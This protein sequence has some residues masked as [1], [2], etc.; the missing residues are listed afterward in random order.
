MFGI[1]RGDWNGLEVGVVKSL[2]S[3][4]IVKSIFLIGAKAKVSREK[5]ETMA[6]WG[7]RLNRLEFLKC[8]AEEGIGICGKGPQG[9]VNLM[10][11]SYSI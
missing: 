2:Y 5:G 1:S 6:H 8:L 3:V 10:Y 7:V 11:S 4:L 9:K